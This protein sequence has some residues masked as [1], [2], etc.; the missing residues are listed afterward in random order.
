MTRQTGMLLMGFCC[1]VLASC[2]QRA[3]EI[4]ATPAMVSLPETQRLTAW[5]DQEF[6]TFLEFSP[7]TRTRL[8][9]KRHQD[10]LD[11]VSEAALERRL[12]WRRAS[13]T[14]MQASFDRSKLDP[15]GQISYDLWIFLL[16]Q[17]E[18]GRPWWRHNFIF[19][20][21]GP[22]TGLPSSLIS[23]QKVDDAEDMRA[24]ISRLNQSGRYVRQYL[25]RARLAAAEGIRA[26][27]FDY[28]QAMREARSVISGAPFTTGD[29]SPLWQDI[30]TKIA[31][32]EITDEER[33]A[34]TGAARA[35]LLDQLQPAY[36]EIIAWLEG[37]YAAN[38]TKEAKGAWALPDGAAYYDYKLSLMTTLPLTADQIHQAGLDEVAR[39]HAEMEA[40]KATVGFEGTLAEFFVFMRE[41]PR[42]YFPNTDEGREDYLQ[43]ARDYLAQ[44]ETRLPEYFGLL[45]RAGLEVRRVEAFREQAGGAAH[46]RRGTPDGSRP[47]VF[48]AHLTDMGAVASYR[49][50]NLAYHEGVPGHHLQISIQQELE[51]LPRFRTFHGYTAFSEGWGLYAELLGK[52][53]GFYTNP[54]N[55]FG[56][57]TGELWRAIRL[58]L[59][60]GIHAKGWSEQQAIEYAVR[61][62][63]RPLT[64]VTSEVHRYFNNPAQ[65]TAY[66]IGMDRIVAL[67]QK[68]RRVLGDG[69]DYRGF[70]DAVLGSGPLPMP[71]LE[72]KID[73]WIAARSR[74]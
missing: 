55:D 62:S 18:A 46:Y 68:A 32:L 52:D 10:Q 21:R 35:A 31:A 54:Y 48:Y 74:E 69:F 53:M 50:E 43:Q 34:L 73:G 17:E 29:A 72:K 42:F 26:P 49:L 19:G 20:R 30:T 67:R 13:V 23:Y 9:D 61:N 24:Y 51:E 4:P 8:G 12:N 33:R 16:E 64:T 15:E 58:V 14:E 38:V 45:P 57:L 11:D 60:T 28:E 65:A 47:G 7:M 22:Q 5:L 56:R 27:W 66:K 37:D 71:V 25:E 40:I 36:Q 41:D 59:D 44:M 1:L 6:E 3:E 70:H 39:I 63:P 2:G